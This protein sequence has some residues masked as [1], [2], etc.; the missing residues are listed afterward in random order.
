MK[1]ESLLCAAF[2]AV[3]FVHAQDGKA[4]EMPNPKTEAHAALAML[5]GTWTTTGRMPAVPGMPGMEEAKTWVG[6]ERAELICDG[7]WLKATAESTCDGEA[8]QGL[9]LAGYDPL[10]K[11]Y[12]LIWVSSMDEPSSEAEGSYDAPTKTWTF[13]GPSPMG[14]FV[15]VYRM[16]GAD[17]S[18]ETCY[19]VGEDGKQTEC[20]RI[21][22]TR[23]TSPLATIGGKPVPASA[24]VA[25]WPSTQHAL[26][27]AGVG[28][29]DAT[30]TCLVPGQEPVVETCS[31]RVTPICSGK[32]FWSDFTGTMMGQPFEGHSLTGYDEASEQYVAFWIDSTSPTH[33]RTRG[34]YDDKT[35][36]WT[37]RGECVDP[38]GKPAKIHQT[39]VQ[40]DADTRDLQM[41]FET[42]DG[43]QEMK[44]RYVRKPR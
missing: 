12:R 17:Q 20:M 29:W 27:A 13:R 30:S 9:W 24:T 5:A 23:N 6:T 42:A 37:F 10:H 11:K 44:V 25:K 16:T 32:W 1:F 40:K 19:L 34:T 14:E 33:T 28:E 35:N 26:L 22:R 31:E 2:V 8:M 39:Y 7:L 18:I 43:K 41:T 38:A 36:V 15:S 3:P 21:E 4:Q